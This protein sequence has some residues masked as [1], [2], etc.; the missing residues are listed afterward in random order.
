MGWEEDD[1]EEEEEPGPHDDWMKSRLLMTRT[2]NR[3][4]VTNPDDPK[5]DLEAFLTQLQKESP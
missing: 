5:F 1:E 2:D 3:A 4:V